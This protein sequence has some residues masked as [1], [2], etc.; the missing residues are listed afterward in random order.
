MALNRGLLLVPLMALASP[1]AADVRLQKGPYLMDPTPT[2]M[3]VLFELDAPA[4]AEVAVLDASGAEVAKVTSPESDFHEVVL[5]DLQPRTRYRYRV[6]A[7]GIER[8]GTFTTAPEPGEGPIR[9][10]VVGD[11]RTDAASHAVVVRAMLSEP[12]EFVVNTGDMVEAGDEPEEWQSFFDL[13]APLLVAH[14]L[15]PTLGNHEMPR[16]AA[17]RAAYHRYVRV[18]REGPAAERYYS[19]TYGPLRGIVLDSNDDWS[20]PSDQQ[21]WLDAELTRAGEDARIEHVFIVL[22]HGPYSSGAHG[23]HPHIQRVAE[24]WHRRGVSLVLSGH[25]HMYERGTSAEGLKYIVTGGGGAPLYPDNSELPSQQHFEAV[26]HYLSFEIDG[27]N[28]SIHVVRSDGSTLERCR[29]E[30]RDGPWQCQ[31]PH[32]PRRRPP[33][34]GS[35]ERGWYVLGL[36][37]IGA[38]VWLIVRL[39]QR[40][41][42]A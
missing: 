25:D 8:E 31:A 2:S 6:R 29:F 12:A 33:T 41:K 15:F 19:F 9:F 39:R 27:P 36:L 13:Q 26:H 1:A 3:A 22:H 42:N 34:D 17:G 11:H 30:H 38:V 28:V 40:S 23:S 5:G 10:V 37:G 32:G 14:P 21:D 16:T 7:G 20:E 4:R 18:P 35:I 24:E